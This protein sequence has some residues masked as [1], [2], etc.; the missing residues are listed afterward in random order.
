MRTRVVI[1]DMQGEQ[2]FELTGDL[3]LRQVRALAQIAE[4]VAQGTSWDV[5][6]RAEEAK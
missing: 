4:R 1:R 2:D 6:I 5:T 3:T